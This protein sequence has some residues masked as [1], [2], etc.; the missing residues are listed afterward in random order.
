MKL[1]FTKHIKNK[2]KWNMDLTI[3]TKILKL[4]ELN[5]EVNLHDLD[6]E[7]ILICYKSISDK[8]NDKL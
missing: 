5:M 6:H 2:W 1:G 3:R 4:L 7:V 8:Q